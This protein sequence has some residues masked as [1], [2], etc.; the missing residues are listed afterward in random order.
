[1]SI[2][3]EALSINSLSDILLEKPKI[4]HISCHG[5]YDDGTFCLHFEDE[6]K[7]R[8]ISTKGLQALLTTTQL[9]NQLTEQ[10]NN[11]DLVFVS[12]CY[13]EPAGDVFVDAGVPVVVCINSATQILDEI[14]GNFATS[15]Y[16]ALLKGHK[17]KD[18]FNSV[19]GSLSAEYLEEKTFCCCVHSHKPECKWK[20]K[21]KHGEHVMNCTCDEGD[22]THIHVKGCKK[23][24]DFM[25]KY[26]VEEVDLEGKP[27]YMKVCCCNPHVKHSESE[28]FMIKGKDENL[29]KSI[30]E[31]E[32]GIDGTLRVINGNLANN[33]NYEIDLN[34]LLIGRRFELFNLI[35][36]TIYSNAQVYDDG[37]EFGMKRPRV[38][39]VYGRGNWYSYIH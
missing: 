20:E 38:I 35:E 5:E 12:A 34:N 23:A 26:S 14:A 13:S 39:T 11:I 25:E 28:N 22:E 1:M 16:N 36:K 9:R 29:E 17:I 18:S 32:I 24:K 8:K 30:F 3:I 33:I 31:R 19:K 27:G 10:G 7:L 21:H 15:F 2:Q 4:L 6:G 37:N